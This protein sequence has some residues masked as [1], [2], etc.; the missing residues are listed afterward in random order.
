VTP[1]YKFIGNPLDVEF[2]LRGSLKFTPVS[3]LNDPSELLANVAQESLEES[4]LRIRKNGITSEDLATFEH[5]K[6]LLQRLAPNLPIAAI[7]LTKENLNAIIHS[8][9][10]DNFSFVKEST[11]N[12][13][14]MV[15]PKV[16][17]LCL[18]R[19]N[20]AL[21]MW[22]Y[23]ANNAKGLVVEFRGLDDAFPGE[24]ISFLRKPLPVQYNRD[25]Y[26][27]TFDPETRGSYFF[28]K[29]SDWQHE[30]EVRVVALLTDCR[31]IVKNDHAPLYVLDVAPRHITRIFLGWGMETETIDKTIE[32]V[33]RASPAVEVVKAKIEK[34]RAV[35]GDVIHP[36]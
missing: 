1:L 24:D 19:R 4:L 10:L 22:A 31:K 23:Y 21:P 3:E 12:V 36:S 16:G 15:S 35:A 34:G 29:F 20:D 8:P 26:S 25:S 28:S 32:L 30:Q 13:A 27:E 33:K 17:L 6:N 5:L 9:L 2:I 7:P 11:G 18:T 14:E